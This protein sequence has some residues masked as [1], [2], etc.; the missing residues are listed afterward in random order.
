MGSIRRLG[1]DNWQI[2]RRR[3]DVSGVPAGLTGN[4]G[5]REGQNRPAVDLTTAVVAKRKE[6]PIFR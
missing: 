5:G 6:K 4:D 3:I 2:V 1:T